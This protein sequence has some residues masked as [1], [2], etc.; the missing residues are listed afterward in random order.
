[1]KKYCREPINGLTHL[2]G[3]FASLL[4]L[5]LLIIRVCKSSS[6]TDIKLLGVTIFG[7]SLILLY[8]AS[9]VYHLVISSE[10]VI[11]FLRK[12]DHSM[13]Y[14]LIAG[15][16]TPI[17]IICLNGNLKWYILTAIWSMAIAG[18]LFKMLWFNLPRWISTVFYIA[19]GW[20]VVFFISPVSKF[21]THGGMTFLVMGGILYT[22]GGIIYATKWPKL[23]FKMF[24]FHEIF[25]IFILLGSLSHYICIIK[26]VI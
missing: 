9:S 21:L 19:M 11:K 26:Y 3:A 17:C 14:V 25:H 16:Y 24:G 18:I 10:D 6:F 5:I 12:L 15:T 2:L 22:L 4:G 1:M 13:I 7:V 23:H 8:T 20:F